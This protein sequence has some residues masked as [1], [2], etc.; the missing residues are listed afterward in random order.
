MNIRLYINL[1][2]FIV[3]FQ[4]PNFSQTI[5]DSSISKNSPHAMFD[6]SYS[7]VNLFF[8]NPE[9][10]RYNTGDI[11]LKLNN[12]IELN[13]MGLFLRNSKSVHHKL[14]GGIGV[15]Y[16]DYIIKRNIYSEQ[17]DFSGH[18][19]LLYS[20][21]PNKLEYN[22]QILR[23]HFQLCHYTFYKRLFIF[24]KLGLARTQFLKNNN[25]STTHYDEI[26]GNSYPAYDSTYISPSNPS[27]GY[28]KGNYTHTDKNDL[29]MYKNGFNVFYKFGVGFRIKQFAPFAAFEFSNFTGMFWSPFLKFQVGINYS[30]LPR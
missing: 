17:N 16:M 26:Y 25:L 8:N 5:S 23:L 15:N 12:D 11:A 22:I 1:L 14:Y 24:Q 9:V 18:F 27:G 13:A 28:L 19:P 3:F 29:D 10:V 6:L 21:N 20:Y 30:I 7:N 4:L 2:V